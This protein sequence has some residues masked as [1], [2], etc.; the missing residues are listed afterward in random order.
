MLTRIESK[1]IYRS[2]DGWGQAQ[3]HFAYAEYVDPSNTHFGVLCA[4]NDF[5]LRPG[6]GFEEH[7]HQ[8]MEI[9][10][11]C[12]EGQLTHSDS[13]GN[14]HTLG[15]GEV[16]Y[17]RA[18]S[19]VTHSEMN[20]SLSNPLRFI[21]VW[22]RPR[23]AELAPEYRHA[24]FPEDARRNTLLRLV[25]GRSGES[26]IEVEQDAEVY[27][28]EVE[29]AGEVAFR[30]RAERQSYMVVIEGE[31]QVNEQDLRAGD[32]LKVRGDQSLKLRSKSGSH[33][34]IVNVPSDELGSQPGV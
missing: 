10:S 7:P 31:L 22:I 9:I 13:L 29:P 8:E 27:A 32:A 21:Q 14:K 17:L 19:G 16:Q 23:R 28:V 20:L 12:I 18:G 6:K 3:Y 33:T 26:A 1:G 34:I 2:N 4:L 11:Y 24:R 15:R 25:S 30:N 5:V